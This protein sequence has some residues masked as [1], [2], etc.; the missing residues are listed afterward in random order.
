MPGLDLSNCR[1]GL[2]EKRLSEMVDR[3]HLNV[4][5][6]YHYPL[7]TNSPKC[8]RLID[9]FLIEFNSFFK[10]GSSFRYLVLLIRTKL[11]LG[12]LSGGI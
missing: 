2:F 12:L 6:K 9:G 11:F 4:P 3:S 10:N 7:Q 8:E 5:G 1:R